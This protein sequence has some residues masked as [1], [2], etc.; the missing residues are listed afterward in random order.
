MSSRPH[1][2]GAETKLSFEG[3]APISRIAA[4]AI[5]RRDMKTTLNPKIFRVDANPAGVNANSAI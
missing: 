4:G 3:A 2:A 1:A 5:D